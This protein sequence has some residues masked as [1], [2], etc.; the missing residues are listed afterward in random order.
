VEQHIVRVCQRQRAP[1]RALLPCVDDYD[2]CSRSIAVALRSAQ[3]GDSAANNWPLRGGKFSNWQGGIHVPA[4]VSGGFLPPSRRGIRLGGMATLWDLYATFGHVA[5]L[6]AAAA[7]ADPVGA[8]ASLPAVDSID[9]WDWWSGRASEPPRAELA[10]GTAGGSSHGGGNLFRVTSV[11]AL[12]R[13]GMKL[14]LTLPGISVDTAGVSGVIDEAIWT[15]PDF[16]NKTSNANAWNTARDCSQGCLYNLTE[17]HTE[18]VDL[19]SALPLLASQMRERLEQ[20]NRTAFSPARGPNRCAADAT[21]RALPKLAKGAHSALSML[22]CARARACDW[23]S[24]L[25]CAVALEKYGGFWG[26]FADQDFVPAES[27][28]RS[29]L[30]RLCPFSNFSTYEQCRSCISDVMHD[31]ERSPAL[32]PCKPAAPAKFQAFCCERFKHPINPNISCT[33]DTTSSASKGR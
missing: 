28:C 26:P 3:G 31:L 16:P 17:D 32:D 11:E 18:H 20:I 14:I 25:G 15:G 23:R 8:A 33:I 19:A 4:L 12:I 9:Q 22:V 24:P 30:Q 21:A 10:I 6:S 13:D 2:A 27:G 1:R 7:V 5:G 29:V